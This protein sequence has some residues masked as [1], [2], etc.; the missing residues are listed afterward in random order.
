MMNRA[1]G[2]PKP[3]VDYAIDSIPKCQFIQGQMLCVV[4]MFYVLFAHATH[5]NQSL[6]RSDTSPG[7]RVALT[8]GRPQPRQ[9]LVFSVNFW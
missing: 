5:F 9:C 2:P 3:A 6:C 8:Q 4:L 7:H 1:Q